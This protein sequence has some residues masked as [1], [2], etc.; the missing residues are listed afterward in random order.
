MA[1]PERADLGPAGDYARLLPVER[2]WDALV[3]GPE[4]LNGLRALCAAVPQGG[5]VAIVQG[6]AGVGKTLAAEVA[7]TQLRLDLVAVDAPGLVRARGDASG[8]LLAPVFRAADRPNAVVVLEGADALGGPAAGD[9]AALAL[10][11]RPPTLLET[12]EPARLD[13][14]LTEAAG[15]VV[16][17]TTPDEA[18]RRTLWQRMLWEAEP[19]ANVPV[20]ELARE[21]LTGGEI[22]DRVRRGAAR[23]RGERRALAL[24]DLVG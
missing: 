11:R 8:R 13:P 9:A 3:A 23:A 14:A 7:A 10:K 4:A 1:A 2:G 5:V 20:D 22:R 15:L 18:A 19:T 17:L 6:P 16:D 21:A 24:D 12:R